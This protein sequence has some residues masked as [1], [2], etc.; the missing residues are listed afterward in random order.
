MTKE[1]RIYYARTHP[2]AATCP[3]KKKL[4]YIARPTSVADFTN[5]MTALRFYFNYHIG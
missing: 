1:G 3:Q 2:V 5:R 4:K